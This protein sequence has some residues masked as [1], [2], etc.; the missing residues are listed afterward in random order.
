MIN[1]RDYMYLP[2][3]MQKFIYW[4]NSERYDIEAL[5]P[6]SYVYCTYCSQ[7]TVNLHE[8]VFS[9]Q[10]IEIIKPIAFYGREDAVDHIVY[11]ALC[12]I[13]GTAGADVLSKEALKPYINKLKYMAGLIRFSEENKLDYLSQQ[14][15]ELYELNNGF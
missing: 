7:V 14:A 4:Y 5:M 10:W 11:R 9:H 12:D 6:R 3:E 8:L 1:N 13:M 2:P 15:K